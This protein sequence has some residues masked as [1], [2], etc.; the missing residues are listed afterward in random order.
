MCYLVSEYKFRE[1]VT[2]RLSIFKV[3][4]KLINHKK[5]FNMLFFWWQL[6]GFTQ[7]RNL[8]ILRQ[9]NISTMIDKGTITF[10]PKCFMFLCSQKE[11]YVKFLFSN[12]L[13]AY[14]IA[15]VDLASSCYL[16]SLINPNNFPVNYFGF[17]HVK[18]CHLQKWQLNFFFPFLIYLNCFSCLLPWL[19]LQDNVKQYG[20]NIPVSFLISG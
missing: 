3:I 9:T 1:S 5:I 8:T 10:L 17:L 12:F 16:N 20:N 2:G 6:G 15:G 11:F 7:D 19:G 18:L 14:R 4:C 13:L